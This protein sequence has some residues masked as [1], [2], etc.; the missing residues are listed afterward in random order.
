M[1]KFYYKWILLLGLLPM[2]LSTEAQVV[3]GND[4]EEEIPDPV[5]PDKLNAVE[6]G[7]I[8]KIDSATY[9][10]MFL[11]FIREDSIR[12]AN[13]DPEAPE[14][15]YI[16]L[17]E[18][19]YE[20]RVV[21]RWAPSEY[22]PW[23]VLNNAGYVVKRI[24]LSKKEF[25]D[26]TLAIVKPWP[27]EKF[28]EHFAK[29]DSLAGVAV[30][31]IYGGAEINF[32]NTQTQPGSGSMQGIME[33]YEE[34]QSV[35]GM[36]MMVA[37]LRPDLAEAMGLLYVD[38]TAKP[39]FEYSYI[40]TGNIPDSLM[41]IYNNATLGTRLGQWKPQPFPFEVTDSISPPLTAMLYWQEG[42]FSAFDIERQDPGSSEWKKLNERPYVSLTA[43]GEGQRPDD[44]MNMYVDYLQKTGTY[45]YR[46]TGY[47]SFGDRSLPSAPCEVEMIDMV[48][49]QP[50]TITRIVVDH[51][52]EKHATATIY[53]RPDTIEADVKGYLPLY[54]H[55]RVKNGEWTHLTEQLTQ[56]G[57]TMMVVDV[58]G[59]P[60]GQLS[61]ATFD[62][63]GNYG[64]SIPQLIL[65][66][67]YLP[68]SAPTNLRANVFPDGYLELRWTPSPEP[69]VAFYEVFSANDTLEVFANR[70]D[71]TQIDTLYIDSLALGLNQAYIYYKVRAVDFSG[72]SSADSKVLPVVRPNFI[73]PSVCRIDSVWTTDDNVNMWWIQSN[74]DDLDYHRVFR[75]LDGESEWTLLGIYKA[76]SVRFAGNRIRIT[77]SPK[78]NMVRR[79]I[80]AVETFNLS[81]VTS[82]LSRTQT[83]LFTGPR[84]VDVKLKLEGVYEKK[85]REVRLAWETGRVPDYGPW[86]YCVYRK[87]P[88]DRDF[89]FMLATKSD[90]PL[91]NDFNTRPGETAQ[92]YVTVQYDDGRR[93]KPSNTVTITAVKE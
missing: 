75:K 56:P 37:E 79:Y 2:A 5:D 92:Y 38:R 57:D 18:R 55:D 89:K 30:Q 48:P 64:P 16:G 90:E 82:G 51:P 23:R 84:I 93:S 42:I 11:E 22:V 52:D 54:R 67:D 85:T 41:T 14:P 88:D 47:D 68:P 81:G 10:K 49:P 86:Y 87:G 29:E 74:E 32:S 39:D 65:L 73:P 62:Q 58:S 19:A 78:P 34:Q 8:E 70:T 59:L 43:F 15:Y 91:Y 46:I 77:D 4:D 3:A 50:V 28:K 66:E 71:D 44:G 36:A 7:V 6:P 35:V 60:S 33:V 31:L 9:D 13:K 12:M 45:K 80:Y 26:D 21:L 24:G 83:F 63:V 61:I 20:D 76:D 72:N 69:D 25:C 1:N 53:F 40:V 27:I 17:M